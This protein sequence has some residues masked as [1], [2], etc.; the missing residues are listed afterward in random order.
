MIK[1][2]LESMMPLYL[3][4]FNT[5]FKAGLMPNNWCSGLITPISKAGAISDPN[6]YRG[7]CVSSCLGKLFCL[8]LNK[9][10]YEHINTQNI[11]HPP[12]I[13]FFAKKSHC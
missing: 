8:I 7:R 12:Q 13:G 3:K 6:N 1:A 10:L 5:V 4:L 9:R 2:N 11:L